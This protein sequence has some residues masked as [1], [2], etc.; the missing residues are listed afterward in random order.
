MD[1]TADRNALR[2]LAAAVV[3]QQAALTEEEWRLQQR[4]QSLDEHEQQLASHFQNRQARLE[5]LLQELRSARAAHR[6]ERTATLAQL[7]AAQADIDRQLAEA[8]AAHRETLAERDRIHALRQRF[9]KRWHRHWDS[10]RQAHDRR[11]AELDAR[12]ARL[13]HDRAKLESTLAQSQSLQTAY[14]E[15][16]A[17]N[18][19][20]F[21]NREAALLAHVREREQSV[22][23]R[24]EQL[25]RQ[26]EQLAVEMQS[27]AAQRHLAQE[28]IQQLVREQSALE[29]RIL[30]ERSQL[31]ELQQLRRA[32]MKPADAPSPVVD[33]SSD[34]SGESDAEYRTKLER[35]QQREN[36]LRQFSEFL[37]DHRR[38]L[39]EQLGKLAAHQGEWQQG[40]CDT[41]REMETLGDAF[42]SVE[43]QLDQQHSQVRS[44]VLE[45]TAQRKSVLRQQLWLQGLARKVESA[46]LAVKRNAIRQQSEWEFRMAE[47]ASRERWL[48]SAVAHLAEIR[49]HERAFVRAT[50]QRHDH[51]R[52][53]WLDARYRWEELEQTVQAERQQ[54]AEQTVALEKTRQSWLATVPDSAR[55][56]LIRHERWLARERARVLQSLQNREDCLDHE[57]ARL[58]SDVTQWTAQLVQ[59]MESWT[60]AAD[61]WTMQQAGFWLQSAQQQLS[62]AFA[63]AWQEREQAM[64]SL[65]QQFQ[66]QIATL[67]EQLQQ[68]LRISSAGTSEGSGAVPRL[69][70]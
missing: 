56:Q 59:Q 5:A 35:I 39:V 20:E 27:F 32:A 62:Q 21:S 8:E 64:D 50:L 34:S 43:D 42:E 68:A 31:S 15:Q 9:I 51:Y 49:R 57:R 12:E 48:E 10:R 3:A 33:Q 16:V 4:Q 40:L 29:Q 65:C 11:Q 28:S 24:E 58:E 55:R 67:S 47:L 44:E 38:I 53:E 6:E 66:H 70:A 17:A 60:T 41:V 45:I 69:V 30:A 7:E 22:S 52:Q 63:A 26:G 23:Q 61:R 46:A 36:E 37:S 18:Q 2:I 13:N 19:T 14:Q 25:R 54:L 1:S